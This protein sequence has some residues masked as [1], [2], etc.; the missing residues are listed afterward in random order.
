MTVATP[1][2]RFDT[3]ACIAWG[4]KQPE[5]HEHRDGEVFA[6]AGAYEFDISLAPDRQP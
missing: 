4:P 1:R 5:Q 3:P 2:A 6:M